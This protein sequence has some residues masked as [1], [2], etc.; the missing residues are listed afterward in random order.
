MQ[1]AIPAF[2]LDELHNT[3]TYLDALHNTTA[4][5]DTLHKTTAH[6]NSPLIFLKAKMPAHPTLK[7]S[8]SSGSL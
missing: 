8:D 7:V 3:T 4:Y 1:V 5:L 6:L 2:L